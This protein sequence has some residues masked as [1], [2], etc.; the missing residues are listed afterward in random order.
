MNT[1]QVILE[2]SFIALS[3][4]PKLSAMVY[5]GLSSNWFVGIWGGGYEGVVI[6]GL[7]VLQQGGDP[8][9]AL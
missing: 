4:G 8:R 5:I 7:V 1:A 9:L 3:I 2:I 6:L